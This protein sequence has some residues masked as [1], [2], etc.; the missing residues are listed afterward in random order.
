MHTPVC[1]WQ[2]SYREKVLKFA[3]EK[4]WK[5]EIKSGKMVKSI[6]FFFRSYNNC[7]IS[8]FFCFGQIL[9]NLGLVRFHLF[10]SLES[11]K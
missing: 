4:D 1:S 7:F 2:G 10:D 9:F 8:E 3:Q 6:L 11:V 5:I